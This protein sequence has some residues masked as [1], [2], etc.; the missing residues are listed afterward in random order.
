M[1][2]CHV[3]GIDASSPSQLG[4]ARRTACSLGYVAHKQVGEGV[5]STALNALK[6]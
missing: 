5:K 2:A 3:Y 6:P 4:A 1:H